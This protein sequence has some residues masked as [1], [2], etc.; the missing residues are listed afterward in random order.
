MIRFTDYAEKRLQRRS[1]SLETVIAVL[2]QPEQ[3]TEERGRKVAQSRYRTESGKEHLLR[4]V[5]E[6]NDDKLVI[7]V[8]D[9]AKVQKYWRTP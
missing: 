3:I 2:E 1:L 7:T 6:E 5:I 9:T 4:V 8:Y